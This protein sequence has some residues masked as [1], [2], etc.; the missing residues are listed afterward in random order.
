MFTDAATAPVGTRYPRQMGVVFG[1]ERGQTTWRPS[2]LPSRSTAH[3]ANG[4]RHAVAHRAIWAAWSFDRHDALRRD[5]VTLALAWSLPPPSL[6]RDVFNRRMELPCPGATVCAMREPN[7][8]GD[9]IGDR[10][11][12][13]PPTLRSVQARQLRGDLP[14]SSVLGTAIPRRP[15]AK[16]QPFGRTHRVMESRI[17][18]WL[19]P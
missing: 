10:R 8:L 19:D 11:W 6:G 7:A 18:R 16:R 1:N 5:H 3:N 13:D 9:G 2:R 14:R 17:A 12:V 15:G 4:L